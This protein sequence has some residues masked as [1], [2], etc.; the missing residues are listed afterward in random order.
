MQRRSVA[1]LVSTTPQFPT[2]GADPQT[3]AATLFTVAAR[4]FI[5]YFVR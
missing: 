5:G 1:G 4:T 3:W 2:K